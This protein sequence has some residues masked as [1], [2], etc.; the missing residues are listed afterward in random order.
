MYLLEEG[1]TVNQ[2]VEEY[3]FRDVCTGNWDQIVWEGIPLAH[4]RV[5]RKAWVRF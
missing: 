3:L 5:F 2:E 4:R 1:E